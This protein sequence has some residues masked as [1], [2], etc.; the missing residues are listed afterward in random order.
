VDAEERF[1]QVLRATPL[2]TGI[3]QSRNLMT[4]RIAQ[5]SAWTPLRAMPKFGVIADEHV[6]CQRLGAQG[7]TLYKWS[8]L[9]CSPMA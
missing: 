2:R 7:S 1:E 8:R 4:I 9:P 5:K 3:E 6:P